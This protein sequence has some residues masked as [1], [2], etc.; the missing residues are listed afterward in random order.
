MQP[1][2]CAHLILFLGVLKFDIVK[3]LPWKSGGYIGFGLSV[4][5]SVQL[6]SVHNSVSPQYLENKMTEFYICIHNWQAC[7]CYMSFFANL[8]QSYGPWFMPKFCFSLISWEQIGRNSPILYK[9][10]YWQD[11]AW[12]CYTSFFANLCQRYCPWFKPKFSF[13]SISWEQN[14]QN[15]TKFYICIHLAKN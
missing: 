3:A 6:S 11:L 9:H 8:Y 4:I 7:N 1:I 2:F 14:R 12:D 13:S 15:F 5:P 10:S